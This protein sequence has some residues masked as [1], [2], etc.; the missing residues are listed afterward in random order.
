MLG[1]A[2]DI[3][4]YLDRLQIELK[5]V[6]LDEVR[7]LADLLFH[8]WETGHFVFIFG[9]GGSACSATHLCEDLGKG[10]LRQADLGDESKRRLKVMS[11]T[12]N[13]GWMTAVGNDCG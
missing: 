1:T 11:L 6:D 3:D 12:D 5:R 4:P 8:A 13:V 7:R 2:I 10:C 9:N